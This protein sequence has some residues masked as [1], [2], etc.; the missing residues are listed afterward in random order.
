M[1]SILFA[2]ML[3]GVTT[4]IYASDE[5]QY[6]SFLR[7][8]W[9]DGDLSFENEYRH[10]Y[11]SGVAR[12]ELFRKT[13]LDLTT[14]TGRRINFGTIG[15]A[16]LWAPFYAAGSAAARLL[17][18]VGRPVPMDGYSRPY[19]AAVCYGSAFYGFAALLLALA[20]AR[21]LVVPELPP[22]NAPG[23]WR[24]LR[25][26]HVA[27]MAAVWFGTP[28]V[29]YMYVA[30]VMA[31]AT[32][33]FAVALFVY[34][35]L[36][37]RAAWSPR[38]CA[39]LGATAALMAMV[40]EQDAFLVAGP[41]LDCLRA[42]RHARAGGAAMSLAS[43][44]GP[45][46]GAA[47]VTFAG[48]F[49]P[50][51][52]AYWVLNG[53]VGPSQLVER[54][55]N[56]TSPHALQVLGSPE[57]GF[58]IWTPLAVLALWGLV[59]LAARDRADPARRDVAWLGAC[60]LV[61]V[62]GQVYV[63]GSVESWSVAGAFGQRRFVA[64]SVLLVV[65]LAEFVHVAARRAGRL[66]VAAGIGLAVWW[67]LGL[68]IQFGTGLMDRQRIDL[69]RVAYNNFVVVPAELPRI[70]YRYVFDRRS[71]YRPPGT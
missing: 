22:G 29:F 71:F 36:S 55:M 44:L 67:N 31:H 62:A 18:A 30:P 63:A 32:S 54:K 19:V 27:A 20:A 6:Y 61:M 43:W 33:A 5:I 58:L 52:I 59:L 39:A 8:L 17:N 9:F 46:A 47:A 65:G 69:A 38:G 64:L 12:F 50:Q 51:A 41:A 23:R 40:R 66:T 7:S 25:E 28:L 34:T 57:H 2:L 35:W 4:R 56:W 53:R 45:R 16:I 68:A 70:A 3:P 48:A 1:C 15:S 13:F 60:F 24:A 14:E 37:V 10:F 21:R 11:D 42:C 26:P 49:T